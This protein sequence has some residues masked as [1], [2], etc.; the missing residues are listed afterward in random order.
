MS[1]KEAVKV[2]E[3]KCELSGVSARDLG[4]VTQ[5]F[6]LGIVTDLIYLSCEAL[7]QFN[8]NL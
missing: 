1:K 6:W 8:N 7:K 4:A 2:E 3:S 5:S